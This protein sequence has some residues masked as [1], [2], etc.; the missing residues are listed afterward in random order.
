MVLWPIPVPKWTWRWMRWYLGHGEFKPYGPRNPKYRPKDA[1]ATIPKWAWDRLKALVKAQPPTPPPPSP[2]G[3]FAKNTAFLRNPRGGIE[4]TD[5]QYAAGMRLALLNV[6]DHLPSEWADYEQKA[7]NQGITTG[8]WRHCFTASQ[9]V[10]LLDDAHQNGKPCVGINVELELVTSLP[11]WRIREIVDGHPYRG[12][13]STVLLG[14]QGW[15]EDGVHKGPDYTPIA[16][17]P[18]FLEAFP[19]DAPA[20]WPPKEKVH[21]CLEHARAL[22]LTKPIPLY[23]TYASATLGQASPDWYD[24]TLF[25]SLYAADD[26]RGNGGWNTWKW[27]R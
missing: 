12:E 15:V 1:P 16:K 18:G 10:R 3:V 9:I 20:L 4:N 21:D 17:W 5:D 11:P 2:L 22:G 14:W 24:M 7:R 27:S 25:H 8:Y 26:V 13:I 19:Q 23:G 6:G